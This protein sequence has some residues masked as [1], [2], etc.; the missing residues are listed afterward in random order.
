MLYKKQTTTTVEEMLDKFAIRELIEFERFCRDNALWEEMY[1]CF[2]DDS[3]VTISWYQGSGRGFVEASSKMKDSAPHKINNM[4][5]WLN[6]DRTRGVAVMMASI[7]MRRTVGGQVVD[8]NSY[9]R[10]VFT[11]IKTENGWLIKT[12]DAIY[13]KDIVQFPCPPG[14]FPDSGGEVR[15]S[16]GNLA[17]LL[18]AQGYGIA[19]DLPGDDKPE[20]LTTL[21]DRVRDWIAD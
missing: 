20:T 2:T 13:E 11:T 4:M 9:A 8:L 10:L 19:N 5:I 17:R 6:K 15:D 7:L 14:L 16:Y 21:I 18:G 3:Q 12:F 1:K